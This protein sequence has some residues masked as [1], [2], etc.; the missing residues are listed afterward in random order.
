MRPW[1][2][3]SQAATLDHIS[4]GRA[5]LT[6]GMGAP[7]VGFEA[8]GEASD[9]RTRAEL[10]DEGLDII[11]KMWQGEAFQHKGK[12]YQIDLETVPFRIP[13]P[14]QKPGIPIWV[15]AAWP[16]P[17]SMNRALRCDGLIPT[18]RP[19]D[20]DPHTMLPAHLQDIQ[21]WIN[22]RHSRASSFD[23]VIEGQTPIDDRDKAQAIIQKWQEV[24]MTWWIESLWDVSLE[25]RMGQL[26]QGPPKL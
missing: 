14:V 12:H 10:V 5:I 13:H 18:I 2:L 3:A 7:D 1:K 4:N 9:L 6:I 26:R 20:E 8:F 19:K 22:E 15:V 23:Y 11:T 17:K 16:R 24:G 21:S 25:M